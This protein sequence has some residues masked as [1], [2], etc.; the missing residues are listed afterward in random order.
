MYI[1]YLCEFKETLVNIFTRNV[2]LLM[3]GKCHAL[4]HVSCCYSNRYIKIGTIQRRLAW[5]PRKDNTQIREVFQ[6]FQ[7]DKQHKKKT[8]IGSVIDGNSRTADPEPNDAESTRESTS[9]CTPTKCKGN[10]DKYQL[11]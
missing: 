6:I 4:F 3:S 7:T 9:E 8:T 11:E 10:S 2:R 5:I 1:C